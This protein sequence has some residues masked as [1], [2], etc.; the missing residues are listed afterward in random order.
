MSSNQNIFQSIA[1]TMY[2]ISTDEQIRGALQAREEELR[3]QR[4]IAME[5]KE[6]KDKIAEQV[7][8]IA[9]QDVTIAEQN[10]TIAKQDEE[11]KRLR[12]QFEELQRQ[13]GANL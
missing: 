9:E 7:A 8:T 4:A 3:V 12:K 1:E 6:Q 5:I 2:R 13:A 11:I 10:A